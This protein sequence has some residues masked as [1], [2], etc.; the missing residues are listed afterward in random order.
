MTRTIL[1]FE[2]IKSEE[3]GCYVLIDIAKLITQSIF[4]HWY[5]LMESTSSHPKNLIVELPALL[6][7]ANTMTTCLVLFEV[8][9]MAMIWLCSPW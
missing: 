4:L 6:V 9:D 3:E 7:Y 1:N 5:S 2:Q 8:L